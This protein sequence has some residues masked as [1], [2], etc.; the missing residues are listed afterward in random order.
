MYDRILQLHCEVPCFRSL[1]IRLLRTHLHTLTIDD[2]SQANRCDAG[3]GGRSN[4]ETRMESKDILSVE[5]PRHLLFL[6]LDTCMD[7]GGQ[8]QEALYDLII[9]LTSMV[10]SSCG[11]LLLMQLRQEQLIA[12]EE[13]S[14]RASQRDIE[15]NENE[16]STTRLS[17]V[18]CTQYGYFS[19]V[20]LPPTA[21]T[22]I[23]N[24]NRTILKNGQENI[25]RSQRRLDEFAKEVDDTFLLLWK[26][27]CGLARGKPSDF[28][29]PLQPSTRYYLRPDHLHLAITIK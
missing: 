27:C 23:A 20:D 29:L 11:A 6:N 4:Q 12:A 9:T 16:D 3:M 1:S 26:L 25:R 10:K 22:S 21:A 7:S 14:A 15:I 24:P 18:P 17:Q 5:S 2:D 28:S 19:Q 8:T 13:N